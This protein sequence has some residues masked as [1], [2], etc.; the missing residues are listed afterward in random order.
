MRITII[1]FIFVLQING[2]G[3]STTSSL[4]SFQRYTGKSVG[5]SPMSPKET[6]LHFNCNGVLAHVYVHKGH[7]FKKGQLLASLEYQD[8]NVPIMSAVFYLDNARESYVV[9]KTQVEKKAL[10]AS[11]LELAKKNLDDAE[12]NYK[13]SLTAE[14]NYY[15]RAGANGLVI[16]EGVKEGDCISAGET[17]LTVKWKSG[18]KKRAY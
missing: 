18:N 16:E 13:K 10:P 15:L 8:V 2:V 12:A 5:I 6:K 4:N 9:V 11:Q 3:I 14:Q 7:T 17:I 1:V